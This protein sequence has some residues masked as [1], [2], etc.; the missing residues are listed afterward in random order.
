MVCFSTKVTI[1]ISFT[2]EEK[3]QQILEQINKRKVPVK[4]PT[5][6]SENIYFRFVE[7]PFFQD[8]KTGDDITNR[9]LISL[10]ILIDYVQ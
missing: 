8:K 2:K 5:K 1:E 9:V 6:V 3:V 4:S 10:K 7:Y